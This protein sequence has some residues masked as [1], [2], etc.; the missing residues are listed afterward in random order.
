MEEVHHHGQRFL[1]FQELENPDLQ[2]AD[3]ANSH[4][5]RICG[6]KW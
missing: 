3:G 4:H 5:D 1:A 2:E 6:R